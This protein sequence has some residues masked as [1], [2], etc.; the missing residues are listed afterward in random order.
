[1]I[2]ANVGC[3]VRAHRARFLASK[4]IASK[5]ST[6]I[7]EILGISRSG[8]STPFPST[9]ASLP[10]SVPDSFS[11]TPFDST[12]GTPAE[13][14]L[15]LQKLTTSSKSVM[16]YF[17]EKL[18]AKS[19]AAVASSS[20]MLGPSSTM[21]ARPMRDDYDDYDDRPRGG[22]GLGA[23]PSLG[24]G[25][26]YGSMKDLEALELR[27]EATIST[28]QMQETIPRGGLGSYSRMSVVF[29]A[30]KLADGSS[31]PQTELVE[32]KAGN[33]ASKAEIDSQRK[34]SKQEKGKKR[35]VVEVTSV[36]EEEKSQ[37]VKEKRKEKREKKR[38]ER[39]EEDMNLT[40][41]F[42][43]VKKKS[44]K[45]KSEGNSEDH[46][47]DATESVKVK[48]SKQDKGED[49]V[50]DVTQSTGEVERAR[51]KKKDKK[52]RSLKVVGVTS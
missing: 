47:E 13:E 34:K 51:K 8:T 28:T 24:F 31:N 48:R 18:Y 50:V 10:T 4:N 22:L 38:K 43:D 9:S 6:A 25:E 52:V 36:D 2:W 49:I 21:I 39:S 12:T 27:S 5:S 30:T 32:E 44:W 15:K 11:P 14:G 42:K 41:E 1:M 26:T 16:D 3:R 37:E 29:S 7:D 40:S 35:E 45:L 20:S 17:K 33:N 46:T 23:G 19:N